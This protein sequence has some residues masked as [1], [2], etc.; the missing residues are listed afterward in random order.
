M[1]FF[2][3][4]K[5][6]SVYLLIFTIVVFMVLTRPYTLNSKADPNQP[7]YVND[8]YSSE[9]RIYNKL[10]QQEKNAY[11]LVL[12]DL[13]SRKSNNNIKMSEIGC[14]NY[15]SCFNIM[16]ILREVFYVEYPELMNYAH[17]SYH[18][19]PSNPDS[20]YVHY[21]YATPFKSIETI[22]EMRIKRIIS[23]IVAATKNMTDEE[24]ILYVY[25]YF[26]EHYTYD[27]ILTHTSM[28]Q[29]IF[30]VFINK[31]AVCAGFAK[32][33]TIIFQN[34]GIEAYAITGYTTDL[35]MWNIIKLNGKYYY[36]DAT[37][38]AYHKDKNNSYYYKGL[39]QTYMNE[40]RA[41]HP[42]WYPEIEKEPYTEIKENNLVFI[43]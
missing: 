42:E 6:L 41:N 21:S 30:N 14:D 25:N 37:V 33:A 16:N 15:Q 28:N 18:Y 19:Y 34:I 26:G 9:G 2:K 31:H 8:L 22:A 1:I 36:F 43:K 24:K 20:I 39:N 11:M 5:A 13:K 4:N 38:S 29:S 23:D 3:D 27:E 12:N 10:S 7:F 40:Y 17:F 35:H 32:A